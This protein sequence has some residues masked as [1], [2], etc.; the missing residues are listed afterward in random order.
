MNDLFIFVN[1]SH[2]NVL[3]V[4]NVFLLSHF[5]LINHL[6]VIIALLFFIRLCLLPKS[7]RSYCPEG[8]SYFG[9]LNAKFFLFSPFEANWV[10][11]I[12]TCSPHPPL[13]F[14]GGNSQGICNFLHSLRILVD[15]VIGSSY[16]LKSD[17]E[18]SL[19]CRRYLTSLDNI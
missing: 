6:L 15:T 9:F 5:S 13:S 10:R 14:K 16:L 19:I 4:V 11:M 7:H 1:C 17:P 8:S 2:P 3:L 18:I 12:K